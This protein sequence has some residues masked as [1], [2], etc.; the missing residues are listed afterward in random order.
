M[1]IAGG[2]SASAAFLIAR[3]TGIPYSPIRVTSETMSYRDSGERA[4]TMDS[5]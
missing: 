2:Q 3:V 5:E 4:T 1:I